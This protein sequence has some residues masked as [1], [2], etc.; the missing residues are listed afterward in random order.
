VTSGSFSCYADES[1]ETVSGVLSGTA[2][3]NYYPIMSRFVLNT[4]ITAG[5]DFNFYAAIQISAWTGLQALSLML[6]GAATN[7]NLASGPA[8]SLYGLPWQKG[9]YTFFDGSL[10]KI[11]AAETPEAALNTR[12]YL[13]FIIYFKINFKLLF[14]N[15][16]IAGT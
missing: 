11:V 2:H 10:M 7:S 6:A 5:S 15:I 1:D 8:F 3:F 13:L 12:Y 16:Y 4:G 9:A 14:L